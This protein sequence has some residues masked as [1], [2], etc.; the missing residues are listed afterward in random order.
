MQKAAGKSLVNVC[1]FL[2]F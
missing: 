1:C 2:C